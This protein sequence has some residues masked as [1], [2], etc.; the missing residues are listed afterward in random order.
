MYQDKNLILK[1]QTIDFT[2]FKRFY[3]NH[4]QAF[5]IHKSTYILCYMSQRKDLLL[6]D[7]ISVIVPVY[8]VE[9][10]LVRCV[11]SILCQTHSNL[12]V[13]LINDGSKDN[14]GII[15]DKF[16]EKDSRVR[17][18]HQENRGVSAAR[19]AGLDVAAGDWIG[20]V[21]SDD[22]IELEM[23]E[24]L[25]SAA[26]ESG[27]LVSV[28]GFVKYHLNG[29]V[30]KRVF[31]EIPTVLGKEQA[32]EYMLSNAYYEGYIWNKLFKR[33]LLNVRFSETIH[34]CEDLLFSI[35]AFMHIDGVAYVDFPLYRYLIREGSSVNCIN[36]KRLTSLLSRKY[37]IKL[38]AE[39]SKKLKR[40]AQVQY[41]VY[42]IGLLYA[43]SQDT[44][45]NEFMPLLRREAWRYSFIYF[46][47]RHISF[48]MKLRS[49]IILSNIRLAFWI[50]QRV[51]INWW[52]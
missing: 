43:A 33:D 15:C 18:I 40:L 4:L 9:E 44:V 31:G 52:K 49:A 20:F 39:I 50:K 6:N 29:W 37:V 24:K 8:N 25:L 11:D 1:S 21:D 10:Y 38:V 7:L 3:Q 12:E 45:N 19:N 28:C 26:V 41:T 47:S 34:A 16:R 5:C 35:Q 22:W 30:E 46:L 48:K 14:S 2:G 23:F 27:K 32:L 17:V 13:I 42:A 51:K 36:D